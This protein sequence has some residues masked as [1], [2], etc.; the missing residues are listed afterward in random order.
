MVIGVALSNSKDDGGFYLEPFEFLTI[1]V[2]H[3]SREKKADF[4]QQI[5]LM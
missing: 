3:I 4:S 2:E 1:I 5:R